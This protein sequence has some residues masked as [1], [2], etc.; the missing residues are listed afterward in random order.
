LEKGQ[1]PECEKRRRNGMND[2]MK[3]L[4]ALLDYLIKHNKDHAEEITVLA[5]K[6]KSLGETTVYDNLT[7]GVEHMERSNESLEKA[8]SV[9]RGK[10]R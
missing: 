5:E 9:L 8:L 1:T 10:E 6:A 2:Q 4:D 3:E 7:K